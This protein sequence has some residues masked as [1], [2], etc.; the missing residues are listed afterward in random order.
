MARTTQDA[1]VVDVD[2]PD[3]VAPARRIIKVE[4]ADAIMDLLDDVAHDQSLPV[5][6]RREAQLEKGSRYN[7]KKI[8]SG[9]DS[10]GGGITDHMALDQP[11]RAEKSAAIGRVQDG[12]KDIAESVVGI[13]SVA[14]VKAIF[15]K[16]RKAEMLKQLRQQQQAKGDLDDPRA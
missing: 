13:V 2:L 6:L 10:I 3:G 16:A 9:I 1:E 11:T 15:E 14:G 8:V 12:F 5:E 7:L 4:E